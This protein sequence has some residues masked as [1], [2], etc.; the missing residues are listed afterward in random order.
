[1]SAMAAADRNSL[2]K[3]L[4]MLGSDRSGERA[5]ILVASHWFVQQNG[6]TRRDLIEPPAVKKRGLPASETWRTP[7][8]LRLV[9]TAMVAWG[10]ALWAT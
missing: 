3:L 6:L 5:A 9:P 2:A 4:G 1:M 10:V 7:S 8:R